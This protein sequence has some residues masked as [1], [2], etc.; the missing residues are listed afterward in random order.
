MF[1]HRQNEQRLR[2][3]FMSVIQQRIRQRILTKC[4]VFV[5]VQCRLV[6]FATDQLQTRSFGRCKLMPKINK[7]FNLNK[8]NNQINK[9]VRP[10]QKNNRIF[11]FPWSPFLYIVCYFNLLDIR[12]CLDAISKRKWNFVEI[13]NA[14]MRLTLMRF[15]SFQFN[16]QNS[17]KLPLKR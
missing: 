1:T 14:A 5:F 13:G 17:L 12:C 7:E 3:M 10:I 11:H 15:R 6:Q 2:T 9:N 16:N 4:F 8:H